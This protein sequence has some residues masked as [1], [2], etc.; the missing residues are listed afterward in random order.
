MSSYPTTM[1]PTRPEVSDRPVA[2]TRARWAQLSTS[3][4]HKA[5]GMI[6]I[7]TAFGSLFLAA[8]ELLLVRIQLAVPENVF[9]NAVT[10]DRLD[11]DG[12]M[13]TNDTVA[14]LASGAS[15]ITPAIEDFTTALTRLCEDLATQ[16][17]RDAG[18]RLLSLSVSTG[19]PTKCSR[20]G[21]AII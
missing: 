3:G 4:D 14:V 7:S 19:R 11:S 13:S 8:L 1:P 17:Q 21:M 16:L 18:L 15:G 12:A 9:M 6:L 10:F 5:I 2:D 20:P